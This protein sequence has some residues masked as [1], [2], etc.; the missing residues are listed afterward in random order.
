MKDFNIRDIDPELLRSRAIAE[1]NKIY[2]GSTRGNRDLQEV[3]TTCMHGQAAEIFLMNQ[4]FIDDDREYKDLFEPIRLGGNSIEVKV[5]SFENYIPFV[6]KRCAYKIQ[7]KNINHPKRVY[8]FINDKKSP[9]Y[10]FNGI[11][12]WNDRD[13]QFFKNMVQYNI[14]TEESS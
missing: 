13:L 2:Q 5:T 3:L 11:Y 8:L 10:F 4:G 9:T 1:G 14:V 7:Y 6:L 12:D